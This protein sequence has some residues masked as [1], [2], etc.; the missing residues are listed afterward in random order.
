M[1]ERLTTL[2]SCCKSDPQSTYNSWF[3]WAERL[4][5]FRSIR[6]GIGQVVRE[7]EAGTFG[8]AYHGSSA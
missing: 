5:N 3:L 8:I 4:K 2:I 7:I 6:R 1:D